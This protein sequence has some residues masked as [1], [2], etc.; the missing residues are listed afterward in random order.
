MK[1]G[2]LNYILI[3]KYPLYSAFSVN[4]TYFH[5]LY[6]FFYHPFVFKHRSHEN[7]NKGPIYDKMQ[8]Y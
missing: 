3:N 4:T 7:G 5:T 8:G 1:I 2:V 6:A